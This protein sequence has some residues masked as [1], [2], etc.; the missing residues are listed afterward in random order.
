M[1]S[2][3]MK[4]AY[5]RHLSLENQNYIRFGSSRLVKDEDGKTT[6][7]VINNKPKKTLKERLK[8]KKE[9]GR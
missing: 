4:P 6:V 9:K 2:F 8:E 5:R 1:S 7:K 3:S